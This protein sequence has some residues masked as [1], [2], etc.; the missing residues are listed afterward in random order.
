MVLFLHFS[1]KFYRTSTRL[2]CGL[3]IIF[4]KTGKS[5][6]N[7]LSDITVS[8][9]CVTSHAPMEDEENCDGVEMSDNQVAQIASFRILPGCC[10]EMLMAAL[11]LSWMLYC[12]LKIN[13]L[14]FFSSFQ[15]F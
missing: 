8:F 14:H 4:S 2:S 7:C 3:K 12:L 11:P 10:L 13:M 9:V 15:V 1:C 6:F 5:V